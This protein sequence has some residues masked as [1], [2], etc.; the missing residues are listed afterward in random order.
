V[1]VDQ[2]FRNEVV[3]GVS[4]FVWPAK[5]LRNRIALDIADFRGAAA[6]KARAPNA[7]DSLVFFFRHRDRDV[8]LR[9]RRERRQQSQKQ[10]KT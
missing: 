8:V 10:K 5:R 2:A 7:D 3:A 1:P 6:P 9:D 4:R